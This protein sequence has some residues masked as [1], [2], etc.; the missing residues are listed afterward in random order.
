[1]LEREMHQEGSR[2]HRSGGRMSHP[3]C[4][5]TYEHLLLSVKYY[6]T[7]HTE[8][9]Q[10]KRFKNDPANLK[11]YLFLQVSQ[12]VCLSPTPYTFLVI[13]LKKEQGEE[14]FSY[15]GKQQTYWNQRI[16]TVQYI[17]PH[18]CYGAHLLTGHSL[19]LQYDNAL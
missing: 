15:F 18:C 5:P 11:V 13:H 10:I 6:I 2:S 3:S 16:Q 12:R 4:A 8:G 14:I 19:G 7:F 9:K 17:P 1:M